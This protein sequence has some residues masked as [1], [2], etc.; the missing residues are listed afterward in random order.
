MEICALSVIVAKDNKEYI[1]KASD[2]T[3]SL[4]GD[5]QEEDRRTVADIVSARM[6]VSFHQIPFN[7]CRDY[8]ILI[9]IS[10]CLP[11][12]NSKI[13]IETNSW[14]SHKQPNRRNSTNFSWSPKR[15][16]NWKLSTR[17]STTTNSRTSNTWCWIN[18]TSWKLRWIKY[19]KFRIIS[20]ITCQYRT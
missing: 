3:F 11:T 1:L 19:G 17:R 9:N 18:C 7:S 13:S 8:T 4:I 16:N 6:Q 10:E 14:I 15:F 20:T 5:T 2:C 12:T